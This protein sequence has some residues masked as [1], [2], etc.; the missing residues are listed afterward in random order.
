M[1][2]N[3]L[4]R[5]IWRSFSFSISY[6]SQ[7]RSFTLGQNLA[8][9]V[10]SVVDFESGKNQGREIIILNTERLESKLSRVIEK[11]VNGQNY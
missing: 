11:L 10:N 2:V 1:K 6:S 9:L 5:K 4:L 8:N 3:L 7:A